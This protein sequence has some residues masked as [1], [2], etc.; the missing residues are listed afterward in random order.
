M[1]SLL[2][3]ANKWRLRWFGFSN[4]DR[5]RYN[6]RERK[7]QTEGMESG[8]SLTFPAQSNDLVKLCDRLD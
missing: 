1:N 5:T 2:T 3:K 6:E 8:Q 7:T 4:D